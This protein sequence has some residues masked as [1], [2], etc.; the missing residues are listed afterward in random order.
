MTETKALTKKEHLTEAHGYLTG[1]LRDKFKALPRDLNHSR[2]L[3]NTMYVLDG[4]ENIEKIQPITIAR[5][6]L[7]GA[8]LGLD[9]L[10]RECYA[11]CYGNKLN[12]Q[13]DYKG[14]VKLAKKYGINPIKDIYAKL[15]RQGDDFSESV[16]DGQQTINFTPKPFNDGEVIGVFAVAL[17][18]D[19]SMMVETMSAKDVEAVR[20]D[21]S[22]AANSKAWRYSPGEMYKKTAL[23]RLTKHIS[24][25]FASVEQQVAFDEGGDADLDKKATPQ[26]AKSSLDNNEVIDVASK[27]TVD[28]TN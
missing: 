9:F 21:W 7:Q 1:F 3:Q 25:E 26:V 8:F 20:K 22:K 15:V 14:E 6:M 12:F 2:F 27:E 16:H 4:I 23:R 5:T 24:L 11:I 19:G 10:S 17:F 18:K 28:A 13:T